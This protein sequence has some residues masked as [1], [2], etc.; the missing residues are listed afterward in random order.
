MCFSVFLCPGT[1]QMCGNVS[2]YCP[3]GSSTTQVAPSGYLTT[4]E[5]GDVRTRDGMTVCPQ[6]FYCV[7]GIKVRSVPAY[8]PS[9]IKDAMLCRAHTWA[10]LIMLP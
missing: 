9:R 8:H 10:A 6:G 7:G 3:A 4:P 1:L 2:V 5:T